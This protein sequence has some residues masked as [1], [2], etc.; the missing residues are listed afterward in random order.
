MGKTLAFFYSEMYRKSI[1]FEGIAIV[2]MI[3]MMSFKKER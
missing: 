3:M 1:F 2:A